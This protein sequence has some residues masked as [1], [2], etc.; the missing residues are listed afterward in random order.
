MKAAQLT[1]AATPA[2]KNIPFFN[3]ESGHDFFHSSINEQPFFSKN[4]NNSSFP[5]QTK[6][7]IG[8]PNDIYEK[9]ADATADKVIQRLSEPDVQTKSFS[10]SGMITPFVQKK[11]AHC[12]EEEKL[13][14]KEEED[15]V[16]ELRLTKSVGQ[17]IQKKPIFESNAEPP[18]S[19]KNIQRKCAACEKE[20]KL[21]KKS[22][23]TSQSSFENIESRL[24]SSKGSGSLLP[25]NTRQ[26]MESSFGA[27]FSKVKIHNDSSAVQMSKDL[28]AQAFTHGSDV[29]FNSGQFDTNSN[30]GKHLLAHE[31]THTIQ[32]KAS[33]EATPSVNK[34]DSGIQRYP[35]TAELPPVTQKQKDY[36]SHR[37][38]VVDIQGASNFNP[39][40]GLGNYVASMSEM[41][42]SDVAVNIK[43]GSLGEGF[44]FV[45]LRGYYLSLACINRDYIL[46]STTSCYDVAP[47]STNYY[48]E[49]QVIPIK[50]DAFKQREKGTPVIV[51]SITAGIIRGR[52]G[53]ITG[54]RPD[55]IDPLMQANTNEEAF[56]PLIY[57][58][59]YDPENFISGHTNNKLTDGKLH[60]HSLGQLKLEDDEKLEGI[61]YLNDDK[62][63]WHGNIPVKADGLEM[64]NMPVERDDRAQLLAKLP[65]LQLNK[66]WTGHGITAS[67]HTSYIHG[68]L[69]IAGTASYTPPDKTSRIKK[70][71]ATV[72]VLGREKAWDEIRQHLPNLDEKSAGSLPIL[73][74]G[75][76]L[77]LIGW[78]YVEL[79][80]VKKQDGTDLVTGKA[81][82][83]LDPDGFLTV[84]GTIRVENRYELMA[85]EGLADW[86]PV[87]PALVKDFGPFFVTVPG[88]PAGLNFTGKGGLYY[89]Y[90]LGPLT[91]HGI[92]VKGVYS[93]NPIINKELS[94]SGILNISAELQGKVDIT[95]RMAARV[96]TSFPYL[97]VDVSAVELNVSGEASLKSY[98]DAAS[99]FGVREVSEGGTKAT[100][101]FMKGIIELAG[102][103]SLGLTGK[104][105]FEVLYGTIADTSVSGNWP[106]ANAGAALDFDYNIGDKISKEKLAEIIGFKKVSFDRE[107]FVK[108]VVK[109]KTPKET[110]SFKGGFIDEKGKKTAEASD[111]PIPVPEPVVNPTHIREDFNMEGEWHILDIEIGMAGGDV[112]LLMSTTPVLLSERIRAQR[113]NAVL[114]RRIEKDESKQRELDQMIS[115]LEDLQKSATQLIYRAQQLGLEPSQ[116]DKNSVPGFINLS[117][118]ISAFGRRYKLN[119]LGAVAGTPAGRT[120]PSKNMGDGSYDFPIRIRWVKRGYHSPINLQPQ[121]TKWPK[122]PPPDVVTEA[123]YNGK[124][125]IEVPPRQKESF[126]KAQKDKR[127]GQDIFIV[128]IGVDP[129]YQSDINKRV[130]RVK[131][132]NKRSTSAKFR[133]LLASY[134][135]DWNFADPQADHALD[136]G[137]GG[138]DELDNIWPLYKG[139]NKGGNDVYQQPVE[140]IENGE[141]KKGIPYELVGKWF[142]ID[143]IGDTI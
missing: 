17:E 31:L 8:K 7:T 4:K 84:N 53:W 127:N 139:M 105:H 132:S 130:K 35:K 86:K 114:R 89:K 5:I 92:T 99:T 102:E 39:N 78:G 122:N 73:Y 131:S 76:G 52:L 97:G 14:K 81:G 18:D 13:Q 77:A 54:K 74:N 71:E 9:E 101:A 65:A 48:A 50:H 112:K 66:T 108:G 22:E 6:L 36:Y 117:R 45:K 30:S 123:R 37:D 56:L 137:W 125:K 119:S 91:L 51:V 11:N 96:G 24:S 129:K 100:R 15:K 25:Q 134:G 126:D 120:K 140:Y 103:L 94:V 40:E 69:E 106:V 47:T 98:L 61:F 58:S 67:I 12:K 115:D 110:H 62:Y 90:V 1:T 46:F 136:L 109:E 2:K 32:Q 38:D 19:D 27:D 93:T 143:S 95:G 64:T 83:I 87:D 82:L 59:D 85:A 68:V 79:S 104:L 28:N 75:E 3:K 142:I 16:K 135:Y 133:T 49:E 72:M 116:A 113:E 20:E 124:T 57:G 44:I 21:Q 42:S 29:Y 10:S 55:D 43:F 88:I 34:S 70:A 33:P 23:F 118:Q 128:E 141:V 121:L 111:K 107:K 80:L 138:P 63:T 41:G 60:F 26:Q